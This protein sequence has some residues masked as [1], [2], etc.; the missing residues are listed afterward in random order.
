MIFSAIVPLLAATSVAAHGY[1]ARIVANGQTYEGNGFGR[2]EFDSPIRSVQNN[3][4]I[5]GARNPDVNCGRNAQRAALMADA[6]PGSEVVFDWRAGEDDSFWP[7][8]TGPMMTYMA[9]CGDM[10]CADFNPGNARWFKIHQ[11][12]R[13]A[14]GSWFQGDLMRGA[15]ASVPLPS[16]LAPGNYMIRHEILSLHLGTSEGGAEFYPSCSQIR[17]GGNGNGRPQESDLVSL[18]GAYSDRDPGI[19]VPNIYNSAVEY[20]FPGPP[21]ATLVGSGGSNNNENGGNSG[22][23]N[24]GNSSSGSN[25]TD[26]GYDAGSPPPSNNGGSGTSAG[27]SSGSC[28]LRKRNDGLV[29]RH[30]PRRISRVM[31]DLVFGSHH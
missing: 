15:V 14:D 10:S 7:H 22:N 6:S 16:N 3:E 19:L 28:H 12:G 20:Q 11:V 8:N 18:P 13:K 17:V 29:R 9:S 23:G 5:K 27:S 1:V 31:R 24:D 25:S 26:P 2:T 21:V 4:P 30:H